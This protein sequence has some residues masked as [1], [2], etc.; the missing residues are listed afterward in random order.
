MS[1]NPPQPI[2]L[3]PTPLPPLDL[4]VE[5]LSSQWRTLLHHAVE[6]HDGGGGP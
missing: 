5:P 6:V 3:E 2:P 1:V 4:K